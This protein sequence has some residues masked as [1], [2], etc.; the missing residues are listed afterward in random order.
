MESGSARLPNVGGQPA[1]TVT[2]C[3]GT[4]PDGPQKVGP[5]PT[6]LGVAQGDLRE[7]EISTALLMPIVVVETAL[8][9]DTGDTE[10]PPDKRALP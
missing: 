1:D 8:V 7:P 3:D 4:A 2:R 6:R 9:T 5:L 10:I